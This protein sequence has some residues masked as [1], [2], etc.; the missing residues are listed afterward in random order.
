ALCARG[1]VG[2][3]LPVPLPLID[4]AVILSGGND[5][6]A[7]EGFARD[8]IFSGPLLAEGRALGQ[9]VPYYYQPLYIYWVALTHLVLGESLFA[10]LL[11]NAVLGICASIGV[12]L[13]ARDLFGRATAIVALLLFGDCRLAVFSPATGLL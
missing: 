5:W 12:F 8:V 10:P 4:R 11:M 13:L 9:G 2:R 1:G 6:L 7:Y 3:E